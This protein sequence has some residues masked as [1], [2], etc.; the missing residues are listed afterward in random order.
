MDTPALTKSF[1]FRVTATSLCSSAVAA[2]RLSII[3]SGVVLNPNL[4]FRAALAYW[5]ALN[6]LADLPKDQDIRPEQISIDR[7][8]PFL[9][10]RVR[11][12]ATLELRRGVPFDRS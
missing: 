5:K 9:N 1:T 8:Q 10:V 3:V 6:A 4:Q 11:R 7:R 2:R 12:P